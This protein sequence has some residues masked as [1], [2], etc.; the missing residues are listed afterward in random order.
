M[1]KN[2]G[3]SQ[4]ADVKLLLDTLLKLGLFTPEQLQSLQ[5]LGSVEDLINSIV[6][7]KLL[8]DQDI[9]RLVAQLYN[10]RY[11]NLRNIILPDECTSLLDYQKAV[12]LQTCIFDCNETELKIAT[13]KRPTPELESELKKI[14]KRP[15]NLFYT[16]PNQLQDALQY[17]DSINIKQDL[18]KLVEKINKN[19]KNLDLS[20]A[21]E[22]FNMVVL[23][24]YKRNASDIHVE[25]MENNLRI[26]IRIDGILHTVVLTDKIICDTLINHI[27]VIAHLRTDEHSHTQ[28]GRFQLKIDNEGIDFRV[29]IIPTYH[30]EKVALRLLTSSMQA[31]TIYDL[32]YSLNDAKTISQA[33]HKPHGMIL[34]TGPTGS[35]K[36]TT[37]YSILKY[38]NNDTINIAT[39]EDP[40]EYNVDGINQVQVNNEAGVT[41]ASGLKTILRQDPDAIMVGEIRDQETAKIATGAALTGHIVLATLHAN[42]ASLTPVRLRQMG[43]ESYLI[44][45]TI[46]LIIAQRL[47][48]KICPH[49]INSYTLTDDLQNEIT[50]KFGIKAGELNKLFQSVHPQS[51]DKPEIQL[52]Q[53][54]GCEHCNRTGYLGRTVVAELIEV[55]DTIRDAIL[56]EEPSQTIRQLATEQQMANLITDGLIKVFQG[57]T[58][59]DEILFMLN[60]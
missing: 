39:V 38:I 23:F 25:P 21:S 42:S 54:K 33:A 56:K 1:P 17:L 22:V 55:T 40:I 14:I 3:E 6:E 43:L 26:R 31:A 12:K 9:G 28:E 27:K 11:A 7:Q 4:N 46:N 16:T 15:F 5:D 20:V 35:G 13:T 36:T 32:G 57:V 49:C 47:V 10:T 8:A 37:L 50:S 59:L 34:C 52:Y 58:T 41:W 53:G 24:A 60:E 18:A 2:K 48:R 29:T 44:A 51:A 30:G 45:A 19:G